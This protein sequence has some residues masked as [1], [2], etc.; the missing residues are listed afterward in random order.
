[1][2]TLFTTAKPFRG[3]FSV[4]QRNALKSWTL[5]HSGVEIVLFG[6]EEGSADIAKEFG[7]THEPRVAKNEHGTALVNHMFER[8][9]AIARHDSV[10]YVNCDIILTSDFRRALECLRTWTKPYLMIGRRWD[11][12]ITEPLDFSDPA[13]ESRVVALAKSTGFQR[14]YYNIDYFAFTR[15]LYQEIPPFAI[16]RLAW[17]NWL[18]WKARALKAPVADASAVVCAVHQNHDYSHHPRRTQGVW[19]GEE[20]RRNLKLAGGRRHS[21]TI[22]DATYKLGPEGPIKNKWYWLAPF[23]RRMREAQ[24]AASAFLRTHLW[25]PFLDKTRSLRHSIGLRNELLHPLRRRKNARR[26]WQDQ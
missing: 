4:I 26:H 13:W 7:L 10:C 8:A 16:G 15:G 24:Q 22:Q 9:Q 5:L 17:D 21:R 19:Q 18:V 12:E 2:L 6:D 25:H 20:A 1:M 11:T 3:H 14:L 23:D